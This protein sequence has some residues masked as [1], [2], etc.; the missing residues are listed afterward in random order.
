MKIFIYLICFLLFYHLVL[1]II[2]NEK[3]Y[4]FNLKYLNFMI[5]FHLFNFQIINFNMYHFYFLDFILLNSINLTYF[6][7]KNLLDFIHFSK[8]I[9]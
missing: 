3:E 8:I 4:F 2:I 9:N 6:F 1:E 7:Q 5:S